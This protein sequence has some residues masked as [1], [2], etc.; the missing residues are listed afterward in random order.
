[1]C[2]SAFKQPRNY[3]GIWSTKSKYLLSTARPEIEKFQKFVSA[4]QEEHGK[5]IQKINK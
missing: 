5:K 4:S 2:E 3:C 1:M